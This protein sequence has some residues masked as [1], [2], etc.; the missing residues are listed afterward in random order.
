[1]NSFDN[2]NTFK[3]KFNGFNEKDFSII[4]LNFKQIL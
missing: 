1:M 4:G 3:V 2:L